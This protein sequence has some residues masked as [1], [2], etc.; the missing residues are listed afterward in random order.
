MKKISNE[1]FRSFIFLILILISGLTILVIYIWMFL[2]REINKEI[3]NKETFLKSEFLE[4]EHDK[5]EEFY[6]FINEE[7]NKKKLYIIFE[8]SNGIFS[9][10]AAPEL[11]ISISPEKI[12]RIGK[13]YYVLDTVIKNNT[14]DSVKVRIIK[15]VRKERHFLYRILRIYF[16][17]M[18]LLLIIGIIISKKIYK[19]IVLQVEM[20]INRT[21][22]VNLSSLEML[23]D[24]NMYFEEFDCILK[25]YK[26]MLSRVEKQSQSQIEFFQSASHEL[27]SP[28]FVIDSSLG[29][30]KKGVNR[31]VDEELVE[32]MKKEVNNMKILNEKLLAIADRNE[33]KIRVEA[34]C[35]KEIAQDLREAVN[36]KFPKQLLDFDI[37]EFKIVSDFDLIRTIFLQVLENAI[38][39]GLGN[40]IDV[41]IK[42]ST[43]T[44]IIVRD[45]GVGIP[46]K[47]LEKIFEE[48]Y[49]SDQSRNRDVGGHGLGL[50]IVNNL[51]NVLEGE[52]TI[53]SDIEIGTAVTIELPDLKNID[54][55]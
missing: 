9:E 25:S 7:P 22:Q 23:Q 52:I 8:T 6:N 48:F 31:E 19:K 53:E 54:N 5:W 2:V 30:I 29:L 20:L 50:S 21:N 37:E 28:I 33:I 10:K 43:S 40:K 11:D 1:L 14:G 51:V 32:I 44:K 55:Y 13:K 39:F 42:K 45:R 41:E 36:E 47:D 35:S 4:P 34:F 17:L 18:L 27:R 38:K 49:K 46:K 26:S 12:K 16:G 15:D 24:E 3:R